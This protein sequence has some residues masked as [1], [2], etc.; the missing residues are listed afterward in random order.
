MLLP[1]PVYPT[2]PND[3][4]PGTLKEIFLITWFVSYSF[5]MYEKQ[6]FLNSISP[7]ETLS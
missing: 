2:I 7:F 5:E 4:P 1:E 3:F 6:T